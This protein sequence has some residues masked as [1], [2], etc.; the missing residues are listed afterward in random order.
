MWALESLFFLHQGSVSLATLL[1][2]G[3][4]ALEKQGILETCKDTLWQ[5][6]WHGLAGVVFD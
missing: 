5:N 6:L 2:C 1:A 4:G 3:I